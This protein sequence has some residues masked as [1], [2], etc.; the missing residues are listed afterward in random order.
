[1]DVVIEQIRTI[2]DQVT[3]GDYRDV[4]EEYFQKLAKEEP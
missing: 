1:M 3:G 2:I 4:I